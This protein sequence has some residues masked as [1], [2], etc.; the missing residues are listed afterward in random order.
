MPRPKKK[1]VVSLLGDDEG[2]GQEAEELGD[3]KVNQS[4]AKRFEVSGAM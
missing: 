3:F 1:K 2:G 4:Y